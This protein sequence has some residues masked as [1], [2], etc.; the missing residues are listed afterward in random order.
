MRDPV[1]HLPFVLV[2]FLI[3]FLGA[4]DLAIG[5]ELRVLITLLAPI[6]WLGIYLLGSSHAAAARAA[7][8]SPAPATA[9]SQSVSPGNGKGG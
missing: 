5:A 7:P 9:P 2:L 8:A 3:V 6:F 1:R 4:T